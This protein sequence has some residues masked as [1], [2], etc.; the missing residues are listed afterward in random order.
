[1]NRI[2]SLMD[3]NDKISLEKGFKFTQNHPKT[4]KNHTKVQRIHKIQ[5]IS[6]LLDSLIIMK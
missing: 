1:M 5:D 6:T 2:H 3:I 4:L